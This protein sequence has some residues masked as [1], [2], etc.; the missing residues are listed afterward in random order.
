MCTMRGRTCV[1]EVM[2]L[3]ILS[4]VCVWAEDKIIFDR[5]AVYWNSS[6]PK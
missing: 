6:N 3:T 2:L 1:M 4:C 5:H